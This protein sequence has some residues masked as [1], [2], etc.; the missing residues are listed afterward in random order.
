MHEIARRLSECDCRFT[1]YYGDELESWLIQVGFADGAVD[2][3]EQ[4]E[5]CLNYLNQHDLCADVSGETEDYD[6]IF[7]SSDLLIQRDRRRTPIVLIQE[8]IWDNRP[9]DYGLGKPLNS[10]RR[11]LA[12]NTWAT[13]RDLYDQF[14]VASEGYRELY[15][16]N[17]VDPERIVVT[18]LPN[19]DNFA[20]FCDNDF[21]Y[22]DYVLACLPKRSTI[23][24]NYRR[25]TFIQEAVRIAD[26]RPLAF[27]VHP[28]ESSQR[29]VDEIR[30]YART[31][32]VLTQ[33]DIGP[34]VANCSQLITQSWSL[35]MMGIV[36]GKQIHSYPDLENIYDFV[37]LQNGGQSAL[38]IASVCRRLIRSQ[39]AARCANTLRFEPCA[40][41]C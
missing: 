24:G 31:A 19:F 1:P 33:G 9:T 26:R 17:G 30:R 8:G 36:L 11:W 32:E 39:P 20:A 2:G 22:H 4:R 15:I 28:A 10:L 18:G 34:M 12:K 38:N 14:C 21:S 13:S 25:R 23:L 27:T 16:R 41:Y 6:V 5:R 3:Q 35:A 29:A 40:N 37:P 7:S